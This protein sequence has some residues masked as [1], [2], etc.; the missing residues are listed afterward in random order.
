VPTNRAFQLDSSNPLETAEKD[1]GVSKK[2]FVYGT[3]G[4][5]WLVTI[6]GLFFLPVIIQLG[7]SHSYFSEKIDANTWTYLYIV[8]SLYTLICSFYLAIK[9][10]N[11]SYLL[12]GIFNTLLLA[13]FFWSTFISLFF[14]FYSK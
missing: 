14:I 2:I 6:F 8:I 12:L 9:G 7:S 13:A 5:L 10:Y 11:T 4:L 1:P 3:L